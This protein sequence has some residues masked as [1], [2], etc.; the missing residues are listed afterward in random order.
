M[1]G[2]VSFL[3]TTPRP[4]TIPPL[5]SSRGQRLRAVWSDSRA[6]VDYQNLLNGIV[7]ERKADGPAVV[8]GE[9]ALALGLA[10]MAPG[11]A[12]R[13]LRFDEVSAA[14]LESVGSGEYPIYVS[15]DKPELLEEAIRRVPDDKKGDLVFVNHGHMLEPILKRYGLLRDTTTQAVA[16]Y[17]VNEFGKLEDDRTH[18]GEDTMGRAK[19]AAETAVTGKWAGAFAD[20]LRRNKFH[21]SEN[22]YRDFRR[23]M[24]ERVIYESVYN[25][26]AAVHEGC[27]LSEVPDYFA[28][29]CDDML[30]EFSRLLRGNLAVALVSGSEERMA[31]Y[32]K[33]Q[34]RSKLDNKGPTISHSSPYRNRFFYDISKSM[35]D[36]DFPDPVPMHTEYFDFGLQNH[37]FDP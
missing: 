30:F 21:C 4:L 14:T 7:P 3:L 15:C 6:T 35:T 31:A 11:E 32:A 13:V 8:V 24:L 34:Y 25:L 22:F 10:Q 5:T 20:R 17:A 29:E 18:I 19:Y 16:Y 27:P 1:W 2:L 37:L 33:A 12:D 9:D 36:R 23:K 28:D 26:V